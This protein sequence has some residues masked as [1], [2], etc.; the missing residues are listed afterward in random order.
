MRTAQVIALV[1]TSLL[2]GGPAEASPEP[3][4]IP[5]GTRID[6]LEASGVNQQTVTS[7]RF[8]LE[9][10]G[11]IR[12][13][14]RDAARDWERRAVRYVG[15][16]ESGVDPFQSRRGEIL[17]RGYRSRLSERL[18]GYAVYLPPDYDPSRSWPVYIALHGGSSNGNLFLG[19]VMGRNVAWEEYRESIYDQFRPR[20]HAPMIVVAPDGFGQVMWRWMGEQDV[21]D[22]IADVSRAYNVD[23]NRI[24]LGGLSN[25]GV[26]AYALGTRHAWRFSAV[27]AMAGAPSW[28]QYVGGRPEPAELTAIRMLSGL[29]HAQN[30]NNTRFHYYHGRNDGGPMRP[31][32]VERLDRLIAEEQISAQG[33][34]FEAGHDILYRVLRHGRAFEGLSTLRRDP[35]PTRVTLN[36]SD[37][38]AARQHWLEV[39]RFM[40]Y[41]KRARLVGELQEAVFSIEAENVRAFRVRLSDTPFEGDRI[42]VVVNDESVFEGAASGLGQAFNVRF[43]DQGWSLGLPVEEGLAKRPGLS[44][45]L[46]D[47]YYEPTIHVYGTGG[48][49]SEGEALMQAARSGA[50]GWP[51]WLWDFTQP[52]MADHEVTPALM[53]ANNLVLYGNSGNNLL[54]ARMDSNLPIRVEGDA[55]VVGGRRFAGSGVGARFIYPNPL[56]ADRYVTV[57]TGVSAAAVLSGHRLPDFVPDWVVYNEQTTRRRSRLVTSRA[58][59]LAMGFFDSSWALPDHD[60]DHGGDPSSAS[61]T[62]STL[63]VPRAPGR[64]RAPTTY[65]APETDPAG[66]IA[67]TIARRARTFHNFR[68]E[69]PGAQWRIDRDAQWQIRPEAEC[70]AELQGLDI[71]ARPRPAQTS[72]VPTPVEIVGPI[73]GV[74]FTMLHEERALIISC[75][76]AVRLPEM[77][78][79]LLE[80]GVTGVEIMSA[81]RDTPRTS[82]HTMGLGLDVSRLWSAGGWL[83]V[84]GHYRETPDRRTCPA[85]RGR[86][87]AAVLRRIACRLAASDRFSTVLT[88]NYNE[89]HR[90]HFHLDARPNDHRFYVR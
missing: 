4:T 38:R 12:G 58:P 78:R 41:P 6:R 61:D 17:N 67:R 18:Q 15:E 9:T 82:F 22:V 21:L 86:S 40:D 5:L 77:A 8:Q 88:P 52:V 65:L 47:A 27:Q 7:L 20:W 32:Y 53:Q 50:R 44:G 2:W 25:G 14:H 68:A 89:G 76:M 43:T 60:H 10:A 23:T 35:R 62:E 90:D 48:D 49:A 56:A 29:D 42:R 59:A 74:W 26:G 84:R 46:T 16:A 75:E 55:V 64:P 63:P 69:I 11:R 28:L 70:L 31:A 81:R 51:L 80:E 36:T 19:V 71:A 39:T 54:L 66:A 83:S 3:D 1:I 33:T 73:G 30:M 13:R 87:R 45:P 37:Y 57:Q 85:G 24:V 34:W 79:I 72:P